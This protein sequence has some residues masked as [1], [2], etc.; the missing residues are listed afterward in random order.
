TVGAY[1]AGMLR[2]S[3]TTVVRLLLTRLRRRDDAAL[4]RLAEFAAR[5]QEP[6]L[7]EALTALAGH[8][9]AEVRT[10]VAR[11][12]GAFPHAESLTALTRLAGDAHWPV[13][14]TWPAWCSGSRPRHSPSSPRERARPRRELR[15]PGLLPGAQLV[16]R[17]AA[18]ALHP[19]DLGA[20]P[21]RGRRGLPAADA[22]RCPPAHHDPGAGVQRAEDHRGQRHGDPGA[23]LPQ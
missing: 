13:R 7:R 18:G 17:A 19:G 20:D 10:Q 9:D 11:A 5:L 6:A 23:P 12:L 4:A 22:E 14:A 8:G 3:R 15:H 16:L 2:R 1:Y 21:A